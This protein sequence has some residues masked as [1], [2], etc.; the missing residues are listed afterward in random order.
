MLVTKS[1]YLCGLARVLNEKF[2]TLVFHRCT[3]LFNKKAGC[4]SFW[5]GISPADNF[6]KPIP[7]GAILSGC[8]LRN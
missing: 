7:Y 2:K 4:F 8:V 3:L 1:Q 5:A 6:I